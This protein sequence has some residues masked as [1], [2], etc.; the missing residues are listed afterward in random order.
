MVAG[1]AGP[2]EC[3]NRLAHVAQV[4]LDSRHSAR[5]AERA[6]VRYD[7]E[8]FEK[9]GLRALKARSGEEAREFLCLPCKTFVESTATRLLKEE[10]LVSNG[11]AGPSHRRDHQGADFSRME[12]PRANAFA[13]FGAWASAGSCTH[14][15]FVA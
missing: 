14:A 6:A 9:V 3:H 2:G 12:W 13:S 10:E 15:R 11:G 1:I 7:A 5:V 4:A 8:L